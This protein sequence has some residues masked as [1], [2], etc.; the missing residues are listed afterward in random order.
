MTMIRYMPVSLFLVIYFGTN[1]NKFLQSGALTVVLAAALFVCS[2][3]LLVIP[4]FGRS[5][6]R[7]RHKRTAT[8]RLLRRTNIEGTPKF[9]LSLCCFVASM[10][11]TKGQLAPT[12]FW[13]F[14]TLCWLPGTAWHFRRRTNDGIRRAAQRAK[15]ASHL[16]NAAETIGRDYEFRGP[17][18]V[19][20]ERN[21]QSFDDSTTL[22][23]WT[24][25]C[26]F[27]GVVWVN[28]LSKAEPQLSRAQR[29]DVYREVFPTEAYRADELDE[30]AWKRP[31]QEL[32]LH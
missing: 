22:G 4:A 27:V 20:Q 31:I 18:F 15:V 6:M 2:I 24:R 14:H 5:Y 29:K 17:I 26:G 13:I 3:L 1:P 9:Y 32:R 23:S 12:I 11:I 10:V 19:Y 16:D 28:K 25:S 8:M 21:S 7:R 30:G